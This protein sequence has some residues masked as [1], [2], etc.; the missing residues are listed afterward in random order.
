MAENDNKEKNKKEESFSDDMNFELPTGLPSWASELDGSPD[1]APSDVVTPMF[2]AP[3]T[4]LDLELISKIRQM[5]SLSE[6]EQT[7]EIADINETEQETNQLVET[8][9][10]EIEP[11]ASK[12]EMLEETATELVET[13]I[14]EPEFLK[15][16]PFSESTS[17]EINSNQNLDFPVGEPEFLH[18]PFVEQENN[19]EIETPTAEPEFLHQSLEQ[20]DNSQ[21]VESNLENYQAVEE[22]VL[23]EPQ[24]Q[25]QN[26][27]F[28]VGEPEFLQD[29]SISEPIVLP[30]DSSDLSVETTANYV[31]T[32]IEANVYLQDITTR[33]TITNDK[34]EVDNNY[35]I[36]TSD[37]FLT[38][39]EIVDEVEVV[40]DK[41]N[42]ER[43]PIENADNIGP[44]ESII[45]NIDNSINYLDF[46]LNS[47]DISST[48]SED[49]KERYISFVLGETTY[50]VNA[51]NVTEVNKVPKI[52]FVPN[53]TEWV[54]GV[55]NLRGD[56][57]SVLD[58]HSFFGLKHTNKIT[59]DRLLVIRNNNHSVMTGVIVDEVKGLREIS[60]SKITDL[61]DFYLEETLKPFFKGIYR[62]QDEL[63]VLLDIELFLLSPEIRQFEVI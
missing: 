38:E 8:T 58:L 54:L 35:N 23:S 2:N 59:N 12:A 47:Q 20:D 19:Q 6:I 26:L 29:A 25:A 27:D 57:L 51:N 15:E 42:I 50:A 11:I 33:E 43:L 36:S 53:V 9:D 16:I 13:P 21:N 7:E 56:I 3:A 39:Q 14:A 1:E 63:L 31:N 46:D 24:Q 55:T 32:E 37:T 10:I 22:V 40:E 62:G 30:T 34:V 61:P 18:Q 4:D 41:I 52:T 45:A 49:K 60:I 44:L 5:S 48:L 17:K 28:P